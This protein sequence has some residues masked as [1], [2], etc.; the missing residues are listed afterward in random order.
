MKYKVGDK[1]KVKSLEWYET[2]K[3]TNDNV[4]LSDEYFVSEMSIYCGK[5]VTIYKISEPFYFL[6]EDSDKYCWTDEMFDFLESNTQ[7]IHGGITNKEL[8]E[9]LRQYPDD[10]VV[11]VEYCNVKELSYNKERNL[12]TID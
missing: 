5:I 7:P 2:N 1:V 10:A 4:H 8:Q 6:E 12:I 9:L 3:D 11:V